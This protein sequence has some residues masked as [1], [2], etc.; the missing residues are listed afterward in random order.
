MLQGIHPENTVFV[1]LSFEGPDIYS[2]AGGLGVRDTELS[3]ALAQLGFD[4]HL[5]FVGDP[6]KP[7]YEALEGGHWHLHRWS[8]WIS[9]F[10]L[11]GVYHGEEDKLQDY[12]KSVPPHVINEVI[13]PALEQGK[14]VAVLAEE[15]H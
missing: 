10:Y 11:D 7:G 9:A 13:R 2:Q 8:Q 6:S 15:W 3:R 12:Q 1:V 14:M 5:Y 4:A